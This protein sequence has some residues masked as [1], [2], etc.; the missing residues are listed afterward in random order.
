M[1]TAASLTVSPVSM[2]APQDPLPQVV[3]T[4]NEK[5]QAASSD[6]SAPGDEAKTPDL[7]LQPAKQ[8]KSWYRKLNPLRW[9]E[10]PPV[11]DERTPSREHG[12]SFLSIVSFQ[13][14]SP[15]MRVSSISF[16]YLPPQ[17]SCRYIQKMD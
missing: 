13:W 9:Q 8:K 4:D 1:S 14:M 7:S 2:S 10:A 15:L 3:V 11:P 12:A 6:R 17:I 5:L 16:F